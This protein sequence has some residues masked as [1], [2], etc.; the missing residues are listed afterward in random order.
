MARKALN[1]KDQTFG[2]LTIIEKTLQKEGTSICWKCLCQCGREKIISARRLTRKQVLSC[3]CLQK[4]RKTHGM[5]NTKIFRV[6]EGMLQRCN[7]SKHPS[8]LRYGARGIKVCVEWENFQQF[9]NDMG[10]IPSP[11]HSIDRVDNN[12]NYCLENCRWATT[13]QQNRNRGNYNVLITYM[14][15]TKCVAEWAEFFCVNASTL[16]TKIKRGATLHEI[17]N[18]TPK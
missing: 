11:E 5:S 18:P 17:F 15:Q 3:G 9:Y 4:G 13:K 6:W 2:R 8:Y 14:G 16:A 7:N 10:D 12:G 1:L